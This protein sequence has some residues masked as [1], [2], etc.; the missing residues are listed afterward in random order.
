MKDS[1]ISPG[2]RTVRGIR[3]GVRRVNE[4]AFGFRMPAVV[5]MIVASP[6]NRRKRVEWSETP[7]WRSARGIRFAADPWLISSGILVEGI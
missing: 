4:L 5:A 6:A 2:V 3:A 1:L 7:C